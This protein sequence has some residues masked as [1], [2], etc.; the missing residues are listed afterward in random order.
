MSSRLSHFAALA[1][2]MAVTATTA[3]AQDRQVT[4]ITRTAVV[5]KGRAPV[6]ENVL[7]VRLPRPKEGDLAN[8]VH[9]IVLEDHRA[10]QVTFQ[11]LIPGAGGYF[12]PPG[13]IGVAAVTAAM[14]R[15]GTTTRNANQIAE[16]LETISA[17]V[18]VTTSM[19]SPDVNIA[20]VA[21][22]ETFENVFD[23]STDI[24]LH[25]SF[26]DEE[27]AKYKTR[28]T[29]ALNQN[30]S[31]SGFLAQE[32]FQKVIYGDNAAGRLA[33]TPDQLHG[34]T[35]S[36]MLRFHRA[37]YVPDHAVIAI[38]GDISYDRAKRLVES[39]LG[40]W[41]ES[42]APDVSPMD[43]PTMGPVKVWMVD[44]PNSVQTSVI[45]GTQA[46]DRTDPDFNV[47]EVMNQIIGGGPTGR[48]FVHLREEK[49]YTYG[50]FSGLSAGQ[51]RGTWSAATDVRSDVTEAAL[52]DLLGELVAIR[53][54]TVSFRELQ[55]RKRGLVATFAL[56][57]ESPQQVL[58][59]YV[60]RWIYKLPAN[61]WDDYPRRIMSVSSAQVQA[62]AK[63]YLTP[64]RIQ[65]IA[66]GD[67]R[68]IDPILRKFG[69]LEVYDTEGKQ[70]PHG[71]P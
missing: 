70:I 71:V 30:R 10:P 36:A 17:S 63:K 19:A 29:T 15:E 44:R 66:V 4:P 50:A 51:Y 33:M 3:D 31:V 56:S 37:K 1:M 55:D 2:A 13:A 64:S 52:T 34:V 11:F 21:L 38:G 65:I 49:G 57:L 32:R 6:N 61:Y 43:A 53:D 35:S 28:T 25:P 39:R 27:L 42:G 59:Y 48:L 46:I 16:D 60:T 67:R 26:D 54:T 18:S 8:G 24:L 12:D 41:K 22:T 14:M 47:L 40:R 58:N 45:V 68:K 9:L 23:L 69:E 62:A 20:G 5:M 7:A